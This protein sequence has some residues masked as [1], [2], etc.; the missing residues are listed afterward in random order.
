VSLS[1][2]EHCGGHIPLGPDALNRCVKCGKHVMGGDDL[3]R[4]QMN[5]ADPAAWAKWSAASGATPVLGPAEGRPVVSEYGKLV[6]LHHH[7]CDSAR[8]IMEAKNHD[9]RGGSGDPFANFRGSTSLGI[10]PILGIMLRMQD[11]MM[12]IKTFAEKGTLK[13]KGEG[14]DDALMDLINYTV[15]LGGL[16]HEERATP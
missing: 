1:T 4:P 8:K 2:C 16:C 9:Y 3:G 10:D 14:V 12:R 7:L 5:E 6:E 11:K 15:L 13:V